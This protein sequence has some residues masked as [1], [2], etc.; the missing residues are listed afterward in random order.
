MTS[1]DITTACLHYLGNDWQEYF[2]PEFV[3]AVTPGTKAYYRMVELKRKGWTD[4][5]L[6]NHPCY[7]YWSNI[8]GE[9]CEGFEEL[10]KFMQA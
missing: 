1:D 6:N 7:G 9:W 2:Y 5:E 8:S 4:A 10:H 3:A